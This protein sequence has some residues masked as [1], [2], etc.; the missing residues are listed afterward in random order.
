MFLL[1]KSSPPGALWLVPQKHF[2][3]SPI[4]RNYATKSA[5][6]TY[7]FDRS[8]EEYAAIRKWIATFSPSTIPRSIAIVTFSRSSGAGGQ[9]VNRTSSKA[10]LTI[11]VSSLAKHLPPLVTEQLRDKSRYY[12]K[13]SDTLVISGQESRVA[14]KNEEDCW[15]K[16]SEHVQETAQKAVPGETSKE[17]KDKWAKL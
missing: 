14:A 9:H 12:A 16:L 15:E 7:G 17:T 6:P 3:T 1:R 5:T 8:E 11:P 10:T 13:N 2:K 4:S